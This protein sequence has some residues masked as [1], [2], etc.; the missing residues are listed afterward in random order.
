MKVVADTSALFAATIVQDSNHLS[1]KKFFAKEQSDFLVFYPVFE[2]LVALLQSR[3]SKQAAIVSGE[4][5]RNLGIINLS[6]EE[7]NEAW[8]LFKKT[9]ALVSYVD[10][11]ITIMS[12]KLNLPVFTFDKH[13]RDLGLETVPI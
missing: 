3:S 1:A 9:G 10:C 2:E 7:E 12:K 4:A 8:A 5:L 13:F 11:A 6:M